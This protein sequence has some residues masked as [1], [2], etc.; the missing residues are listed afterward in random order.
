MG[1]FM[2]GDKIILAIGANLFETSIT[3]TQGNFELKLSFDTLKTDKTITATLDATDKAG[4]IVVTKSPSTVYQNQ[5]VSNPQ[6]Q[7]MT[8]KILS[9]AN[10]DFINVTEATQKI[11]ITGQVTGKNLLS[12]QIVTLAISDKTIQAAIDMSGHFSASVAANI[13]TNAPNY[14][15]HASIQGRNQTTVSDEKQYRVDVD[16][17]ASIDISEVGYAFGMTDKPNE[18]IKVTGQATFEAEYDD[19]KNTQLVREAIVKI[20]DK[21][22]SVGVR[23][24]KFSLDIPKS[25]FITLAGKP[26]SYEFRAETWRYGDSGQDLQNNTPTIYNIAHPTQQHQQITHLPVKAAQ[27]TLDNTFTTTTNDIT[28]LKEITADIIKVSGTVT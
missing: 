27:V 11:I 24:G 15:I 18:L 14:T 23:D 2:V 16:V 28:H 12:D 13:L 6:A 17:A 1:E 20:S 3:N 19:P 9:I 4:N 25:E 22:Y 26:I 7:Q 8:V 5:A 10:D 21:Q